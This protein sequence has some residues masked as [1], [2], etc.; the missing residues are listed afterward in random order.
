[1]FNREAECSQKGAKELADKVNASE[2]AALATICDGADQVFSLF[3]AAKPQL[4][5]QFA[6][7]DMWRMT[8]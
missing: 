8:I 3:K 2:E 4:S 7:R 5:I 1:M 6:T